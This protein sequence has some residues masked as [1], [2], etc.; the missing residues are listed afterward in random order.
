M[1][2]KENEN[3]EGQESRLDANGSGRGDTRRCGSHGDHVGVTDSPF[4]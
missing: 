3:R 2:R 1:G 4:V